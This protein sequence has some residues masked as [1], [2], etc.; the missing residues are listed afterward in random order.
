MPTHKPLARLLHRSARLSLLLAGAC[1]LGACVASNTTNSSA[2]AMVSS[3]PSS[4]SSTISSSSSPVIFSSEASSSEASSS[5]AAPIPSTSSFEL[6]S[7]VTAE[8]SSSNTAFQAI[9]IQ[10]QNYNR[11]NFRES[12]PNVREG[13]PTGICAEGDSTLI[14]LQ[15]VTDL[16]GQCAIAYTEIGEYA[17]YTFNVPAGDYAITLRTSSD[18]GSNANQDIAIDGTPVASLATAGQGW[19]TYAFST[20]QNLSLSA[21]QHTLRITFTK[22]PSNLNFIDINAAGSSSSSSG[23]GSTSSTSG[24]GTVVDDASYNSAKSKGVKR[25]GAPEFYLGGFEA[26][27]YACFDNINLTGVKSL[28]LR[29]G[30]LHDS[31]GRVAVYLGS[32]A[33]TES[34][35]AI[36]PEQGTNLGEFVTT[37]TGG[38]EIFSNVSFRLGAAIDGPQTLCFRAV[39]GG[40]VMNLDHFTLSA[41]DAGQH[42]PPTNYA[43]TTPTAPTQL[44]K[45]SVKDGQVLYGGEA[46]SIAGIS[47]FWSNFGWG[48]EGFYNQHMVKSLKENWNAKLIRVAF[49]TDDYGSYFDDF[50]SHRLQLFSVV[51]AAIENDMYVIIDWHAHTIKTDATNPARNPKAFFSEMAQRYGKFNNVIYEVFNEPLN[52]SW[53]GSIK[54]YA[55][56]VIAEIR[57]HDPDNLIIVGTRNWS[58]HV[59]EA[60]SDPIQQN[61]IA[62]TLHFYADTHRDDI[63]NLARTAI[64]RKAAI[65]VTEWGTVAAAGTGNP[66]IAETLKWMDFLHANNISHANWALVDNLTKERVNP[67]SEKHGSS[68]LKLGSDFNGNWSTGDLTESGQLVMDILENWDNWNNWNKSPW[69]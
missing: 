66:N 27:N 35:S 29:Y 44:P 63:R 32:G 41:S 58:Q 1:S 33:I 14:D 4:A 22:G 65:F 40:G 54:P 31:L 10:A 64:A 52:E 15:N 48:G 16:N 7:S 9:R 46:K 30:R 8:S 43:P 50:W 34:P 45:I 19:A 26:G 5:S 21:G 62:Y 25:Y 68:I 17:E 49:G 69:Q 13:M 24:M 51:D 67:A 6:S 23:G 39:F 18:V 61:N 38:Y 28:N 55:E 12:T 2:S 59:D 3:S 37:S 53:S 56:G 57:K 11:A 36:A 60:A 20:A 42:L 47:L